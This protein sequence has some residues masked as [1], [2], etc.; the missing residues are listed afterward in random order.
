MNRKI[1][2]GNQYEFIVKCLLNGK[3]MKQT[4]ELLTA[5]GLKITSRGLSSWLKRR[6]TRIEK[7]V[8]KFVTPSEFQPLQPL[9]SPVLSASSQTLPT[10]Q[11]SSLVLPTIP[12]LARSKNQNVE[13]NNDIDALIRFTNKDHI[14]ASTLEKPS[15]KFMQ[16]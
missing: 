1:L 6:K 9:L 3:N 4:A 7:N 13:R 16:S 2:L 15:K 12:N 5:Q 11:R 14:F 8:A 10:A